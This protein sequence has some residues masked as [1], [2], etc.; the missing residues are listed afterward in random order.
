MDKNIEDLTQKI[1]QEAR[2][3]NPDKKDEYNQAILIINQLLQRVNV[4]KGN[5]PDSLHTTFHPEFIIESNCKN[6]F[7]NQTD[8]SHV[9]M[10][11]QLEEEKMYSNDLRIQEYLQGLDYDGDRFLEDMDKLNMR[12]F[13]LGEDSGYIGCTSKDNIDVRY[14]LSHNNYILTKIIKQQIVTMDDIEELI[15]HKFTINHMTHTLH[16]IESILSMKER[17]RSIIDQGDTDLL[18]T[19][20]SIIICYD[21]DIH[22]YGENTH[23]RLYDIVYAYI[24]HH[25]TITND[26]ERMDDT[27]HRHNNTIE[28]RSILSPHSILYT[29]SYSCY[30]M[31]YVYIH[32]IQYHN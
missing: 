24:H 18:Y 13:V 23:S 25:D 32:S 12:S 15:S 14:D 19:I 31:D 17:I 11:E 10:L 30:D 28:V 26:D 1:L 5:E 29:L 6:R 16:D 22:Y 4:G 27:T 20:V 9:L 2:K 3:R 8:I 21:E 7:E